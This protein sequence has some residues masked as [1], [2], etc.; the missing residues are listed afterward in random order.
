MTLRSRDGFTLVELLVAVLLIDVG[1]L[2][3]VAGTGLIVRRQNAMRT[4]AL[5][6]QIAA[7]R[8]QL[9]ESGGCEALTASAT[10][11]GITERFSADPMANGLRDLR[12]S[13]SFTIDGAPRAVVIRSRM[14]C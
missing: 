10:Q 1:V 9:L 8:I 5:A 3:M 2:A 12:D 13:V 4:R 11:P 14:S 7:N 6:A